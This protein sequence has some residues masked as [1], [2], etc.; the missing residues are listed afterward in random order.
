[1]TDYIFSQNLSD[2]L[3]ILAQNKGQ[4]TSVGHRQ[5]EWLQIEL[6]LS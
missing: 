2:E 3:L 1:M 6:I 4:L 5:W